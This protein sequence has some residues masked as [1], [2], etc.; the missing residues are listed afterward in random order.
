MEGR[1]T[2]ATRTNNK[3]NK[4]KQVVEEEEEEESV[5]YIKLKHFVKLILV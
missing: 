5:F 2:R 4:K 3:K 1:T